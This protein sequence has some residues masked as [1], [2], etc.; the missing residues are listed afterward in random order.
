MKITVIRFP[1]SNCDHDVEHVYGSVLGGE[2]STVWHKERDLKKADIVVL[3]GGFSFG[4]YLRTGALAR[5]SP[6]MEE[7]KRFSDKGGSVIG[8]CNG[9]QILCEC[10]LLPGVLLRNINT[11]F[12]SRMVNIRVERTTTPFTGKYSKGD[13]ITCPI[14][15]GEGNYFCDTETLKKLEGEGQVV[16]RYSDSAGVRADDNREI[17]P[18]GALNS[19]AGI[20]NSNG[21]IVGL[22]PHP[23][24][25]VEEMIG[26]IGKNSGLDVFQSSLTGV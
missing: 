1:G 24:R 4:D 6:I 2:V 16:F 23:E 7:V 18:N 9:F 14:A 10:G 20:S 15:H 12:L 22:M 25:A 26:S 11:K 19:I 3:P 5:V 13:V 8:I 21:N 17:N